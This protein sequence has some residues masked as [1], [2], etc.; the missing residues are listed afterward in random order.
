MG[1]LVAFE[2]AG[3]QELDPVVAAACLA[4]GFVYIHPFEDGNG[5]LHRYLI[6]HVLAERGFSPRGIVFPVSAVMLREIDEY[7]RV[8]ETHSSQILPLINW[9]PTD[10]GNVRVLNDTGDF[11]RYFDATRQAEFLFHCVRET[12]E[13]DLPDETRFLE[14]Y[15]RFGARVQEIV[16]MPS[17]T[18][19]L[20]FRFLQQNGGTLSQR[21]RERE[22]AALK[23][24][25]VGRVEAIYHEELGSVG[26]GAAS[27][28]GASMP[29]RSARSRNFGSM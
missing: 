29:A 6:H 22:F 1:G 7:R 9:E 12:L 8:L 13:R 11:Y 17:A 18:V 5:R 19:D 4:F 25:E 20:L 27:G 28:N 16:D 15:D 2:K 26:V 3:G 24:D 23:N 21:A 10:S 14:A